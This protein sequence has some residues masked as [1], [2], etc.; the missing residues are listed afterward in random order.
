MSDRVLGSGF[1]VLG[2]EEGQSPEPKTQ[3]LQPLSFCLRRFDKVGSTND[4]AKELARQGAAEGTAVVAD[5]QT[6]GRGRLQRTWASPKGKGIYLS[7]ILRPAISLNQAP[8]LTM[9]TAVAVAQA[10]R[11]VTGLKAR[12]KWPND[13][14]INGK[15]VCGILTEVSA[16]G[17]NLRFA[18]VGIGIN[19]LMTQDDLPEQVRD[20]ATSLAIELRHREGEAPAESVGS[21]GVGSAGVGSAGAS[22]SQ[23]IDREQ[24]LQT[25]LQSLATYYHR[26]LSEPFCSILD[27][28]KSLDIALGNCVT[29]FDSNTPIVG[30]AEDVD[31]LGVLSLRLP[32]GRWQKVVAGE[33]SLRKKS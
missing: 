22:P 33:V 28:Y 26:Y 1:W 19:V 21:A 27:E 11:Q 12:T 24:V 3:N 6:A 15:K 14:L 31:E 30:V 25:V 2:S 7:I 9:L 32:D 20:S 8:Q 10:I 18:V 16:Q 29:V 13:V 5:R 23:P 4:I 17:A